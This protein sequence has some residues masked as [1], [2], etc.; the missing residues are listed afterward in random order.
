MQHLTSWLRSLLPT[1]S[2]RRWTLLAILLAGLAL[3]LLLWA[4]PVHQPANDEVE[5]L[6]VARDLLAGRGWQ[7]YASYPWLRAPLYPLWLAGSLALCGGDA[8]LAALP[9]IALSVV[10]LWLLWLLGRRVAAHAARAEQAGLWAAGAGALLLTQA[11][12]ANLW[13]SE[14]LWSTLWL[15]T[16]L[17][18]LRWQAR[19]SWPSSALAGVALG[20]TILT[21]SLPLAFAPLIVAW[22]LWCQRRRAIAPVALLTLACCATIAPWTLRNWRAYGQPILVETG[23]SYNLWAFSEPGLELSTI[24][25]TLSAIPNPAE[26]ADYAADQG[27]ALLR[28]DPAIVLRKLWPNMVYLWRVKPIEDRFLQPNYYRDVPLGY[29]VAA[30][31]FDDLAYVLLLLAAL[32]GLAHAPRDRRL[33]L[34]LLWLLYVVGTTAL[35]HGEARYR[36]FL[37]PVLLPYAGLAMA[38]AGVATP[39]WQ[40]ATAAAAALIIALAYLPNYPWSWAASQTARGWHRQQGQQAL[41]VHDLERAHREFVAAVSAAPSPDGWIALGSVDELRGDFSAAAEDY[42]AAINLNTD[43]P[44]GPLRYGLLKL[45]QGDLAAVRDAWNPPYVPDDV[46]LDWAWQ[47]DARPLTTTLDVGGGLDLGLLSGVYPAESEGDTT[48]RWTSAST[49]LRLPGGGPALLALRLRDPRP[50]GAPA[51]NLTLCA[52]ACTPISSSGSWRVIWLVLPQQA[53]VRELRLISQPWRPDLLGVAADQ[54]QL[55][56]QLDWLSLMPLAAT[57][58]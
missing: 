26:R 52:S 58:R 51:A 9:N 21:R 1:T 37:W 45:R 42:A 46:M 29:F 4:L 19:P 54:R 39:R 49:T 15:V 27:Y 57:A 35:T 47:A 53:D 3:R 17:L 20:L 25:A 14:T 32:W 24:N 50:S 38:R 22:M 41:S 55:G 16:L 11:T 7:F 28:A 12:F 40:R 43:Y 48:Y 36:H 33:A 31:V 10:Q 18:L 6:S 2:R 23:F 8:H 44:D 30:L 5:Y 13:M 34:L 56:V